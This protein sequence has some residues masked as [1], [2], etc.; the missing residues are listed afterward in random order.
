MAPK[1]SKRT[2]GGLAFVAATIVGIQ[3]ASQAVGQI[4]PP[5]A[6]ISPP[7][8][9]SSQMPANPTGMNPPGVGPSPTTA[10]PAQ[11]TPA[12]GIDPNN[13]QS[14]MNAPSVPAFGTKAHEIA[15]KIGEQSNKDISSHPS[16]SPTPEKFVPSEVEVFIPSPVRVGDPRAILRTSMG[17]ITIH[18]FP[19]TAPNNVRNFIELARG[20]HEF[21]DAKTSRKA[22]RPFYTNLTFHR[23]IPGYLIQTG[24]P[25]GTGRGGPGYSV[26]DEISPVRKFS[27]AGI[28]AMAPQRDGAKFVKDSNG[29]QF[30]ITLGALPEWDDKYTIIGE[31]ERGM[32][33]VQQIANAKTGPTDRPIRRVFLNQIEIVDEATMNALPKNAAPQPSQDPAH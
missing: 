9:P 8:R 23:V 17:D 2:I 1:V 21:T 28:V 19:S 27:K 24:C 30:F 29:S 25:F 16:P 31:V 3:L 26:A 12:N 20:D 14:I 32:H 5:T 7:E 15:D 13:T 18:L 4:P 33:V 6:P 10:A 22:R 11:P